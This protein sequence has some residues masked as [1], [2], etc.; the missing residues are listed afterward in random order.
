MEVNINK[1]M[2]MNKKYAFLR[3]PKTGS[4]SMMRTLI[5]HNYNLIYTNA[6][7]PKISKIRKYVKKRTIFYV[8]RD[9]VERFLSGCCQFTKFRGNA[10]S[11]KCLYRG[12][13]LRDIDI[14]CEACDIIHF[15][16]YYYFFDN[17][18]GLKFKQ[19]IYGEEM[20]EE[21]KKMGID[22]EYKH[23]TYHKHTFFSDEE[24]ENIINYY[25]RPEEFPNNA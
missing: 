25:G 15:K 22:F 7:H 14:R 5:D 21:L 10:I 20:V 18:E 12:I 23:T 8:Y 24:I 19:I 17:I 2:C 9:P 4:T 6:T 1:Y 13:I 16:P 3:L 11:Y